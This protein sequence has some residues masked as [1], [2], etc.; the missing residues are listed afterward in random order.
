MD[1][2]QCPVTS[3]VSTQKLAGDWKVTY[4]ACLYVSISTFREE[5]KVHFPLPF[6]FTKMQKYIP[7]AGTF[8]SLILPHHF[9]DFK[10]ND[11]MEYEENEGMD[12]KRRGW[13]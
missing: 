8:C 7:V 13:G 10:N 3:Q 1:L 9:E 4:G 5:R 2:K 6:F 11:G 12:P